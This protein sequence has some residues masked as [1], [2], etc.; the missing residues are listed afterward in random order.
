[1]KDGP[2]YWPSY[3]D[4][5]RH[6]KNLRWLFSGL[7]F[8]RISIYIA[9]S[10][11]SVCCSHSAFDIHSSFPV[12]APR[13]VDSPYLYRRHSFLTALTKSFSSSTMRPQHCDSHI[14]PISPPFL[15]QFVRPS[16]NPSIYQSSQFSVRP[17]LRPSSLSARHL[18]L[19]TRFFFSSA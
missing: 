1:M 12:V 10:N 11:V 8:Q 6:P 4:A 5:R 7:P 17:S 19:A 15:R 9:F 16:K 18:L 2:A 3:R 14:S 13:F